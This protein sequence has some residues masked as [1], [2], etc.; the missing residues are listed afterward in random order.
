MSVP[1]LLC[2]QTKCVPCLFYLGH[3]S[4]YHLPALNQQQ[5][6]HQ[7]NS[8][9]SR[10]KARLRIS[11]EHGPKQS[12][13]KCSTCTHPQS[14]IWSIKTRHLKQ[15]SKAMSSSELVW[16]ISSKNSKKLGG[17]INNKAGT[18]DSF[19]MIQ[20][21]YFKT[22]KNSSMERTPRIISAGL[23]LL[24]KKFRHL[25]TRF[26]LAQILSNIEFKGKGLW[27]TF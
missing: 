6:Q 24:V 20:W 18:W 11:N 17:W 13:V 10:S 1:R 22:M 7:Q 21:S 4:I 16:S 23:I 27:C 25:E 14:R 12:S 9:K 5:Q 15:F 26:H 19:E 3:Q 2:N 8:P